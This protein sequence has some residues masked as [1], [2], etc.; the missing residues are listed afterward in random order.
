[1][2]LLIGTMEDYKLD[3]KGR[4]S[5]PTKWRERLGREFYMTVLKVHGYECLALY[6]EEKFNQMYEAMHGASENLNYDTVAAFTDYAEE[7]VLDAQGRFT[8]NQRLK[9]KVGLSNETIVLF[10]GR[11]E[12]IEIW[13]SNIF[14][15]IQEAKQ[16]NE[17]L[18]DLMDK[19]KGNE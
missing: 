7:T 13:D 2:K 19:Q 1:M 4:L 6:P 12:F 5:I 8:V 18:F 9:A 16:S 15:E 11:G 14:K 17:G 10:K 3:S